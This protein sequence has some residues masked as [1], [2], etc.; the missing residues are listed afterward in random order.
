VPYLLDAC[1]SVGQLTI[2]VAE[3]GCDLLS[4]TGRKFLRGPRGTGFLYVSPSVLDQIEPPQLDLHS[5][6][7]VAPDRYEMQPDASRFESWE[8]SVAGRIG[9][10]VAIDYALAWGIPAIEARIR[11]LAGL[12]RERLA[13]RPGVTVRDQGR[14]QCAIVSFT[15]DGVP[16]AQVVRQLAG[17]GVNAWLINASNALY[18]L[19]SR[20]LDQVVRAS[21]HYYN[22]AEEI[23][24]L[25]AALPSAGP[26]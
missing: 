17:A 21:V 15:V 10:G 9:L 12:L 13:E 5:A 23:D 1:Q 20:G 11:D 14:Q 6:T 3:I 25:C 22:T 24:R 18:D 16:P 2:D 4:A 19:G 26:P 7:W 8:G